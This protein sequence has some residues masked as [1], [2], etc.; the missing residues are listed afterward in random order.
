MNYFDSSEDPEKDPY[1]SPSSLDVQN[2]QP[3]LRVMAPKRVKPVL[4]YVLIA[5][6]VLFYFG[7]LVIEQ[8]TGV[9]LLFVFLG[10]I[11]PAILEGQLWRLITPV[12]LHGSVFHLLANMYALY[13]LGR[14]NE[15]VN[16]HLRFGL[17]YFLAAFGG[18]VLSFVLGKY[19]S[20]GASTATFGLLAAEGVFIWQNKSFFANKGKS[21]LM[22]VAMILAVN[23]MIGLNS[24]G[25]ID[26]WGHLGG[27]IAGFFFSFLS[28]VRWEIRRVN[29]LPA[30]G[31]LRGIKEVLMAALLVFVAFAA[32]AAIPFLR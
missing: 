2:P 17:L 1:Q 10:K 19:N 24:G 21:S 28:G 31:D 6:T 26:N 8:T 22:N 23:L 9:D 5:V 32:I 12:F 25:M 4:T 16:G 27:L 14:S 3:Q 13:I 20:L 29:G 30:F 11:N 15:T 7:Q 18:N